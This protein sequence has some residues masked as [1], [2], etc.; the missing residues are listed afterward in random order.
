MSL[1][2]EG[3]EAQEEFRAQFMTDAAVYRRGDRECAVGVTP[4]ETFFRTSGENGAATV[5]RAIDFILA[6]SEIEE[7]GIP[8]RGDQILFRGRRFEVANPDGE[9]CWRWS[10]AG[11]RIYRIHTKDTGSETAR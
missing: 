1:F 9:P 6:A 10:D 4:G 2:T 11:H 5:I 7:I 8:K 3:L